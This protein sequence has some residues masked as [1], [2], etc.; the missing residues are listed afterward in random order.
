MNHITIE[1]IVNTYLRVKKEPAVL[2]GL[3][4]SILLCFTSG[5]DWRSALPGITGVVT[6]FFVSPA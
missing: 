3:A 2:I 5:A 6:R 1:Q 4:G